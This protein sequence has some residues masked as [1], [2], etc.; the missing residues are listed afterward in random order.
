MEIRSICFREINNLL[1]SFG[2]AKKNWYWI[3][4]VGKQWK[5]LRRTF[6]LQESLLFH[7]LQL[8]CQCYTNDRTVLTVCWR[9]CSLRKGNNRLDNSWTNWCGCWSEMLH[10]W[11]YCIWTQART[12]KVR[13]RIRHLPSVKW[14]LWNLG[15]Q[16]S[17]SRRRAW[18]GVSVQCQAWGQHSQLKWLLPLGWSLIK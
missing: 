6:Y 3:L 13:W 11:T 14:T 2:G 15:H 4:M 12:T 17:K 5:D 18:L 10:R 16:R 7:R 9:L 1:V 8:D